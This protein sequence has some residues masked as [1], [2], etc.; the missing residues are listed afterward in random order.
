MLS[1]ASERSRADDLI[2]EI[3][4][5]PTTLG[6]KIKGTWGEVNGI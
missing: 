6:T 3:N 4:M 1:L 2:E 5:Y